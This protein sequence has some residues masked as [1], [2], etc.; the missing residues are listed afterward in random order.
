MH[1]MN[2]AEIDP[3][4]AALLE[5]CRAAGPSE[6]IADGEFAPTDDERF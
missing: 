5:E 2:S 4:I 6:I 1:P 3:E